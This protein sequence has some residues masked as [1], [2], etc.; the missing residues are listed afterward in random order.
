MHSPHCHI[1]A[2][3]AIASGFHPLFLIGNHSIHHATM[4][5]FSN[6]S[7]AFQQVTR[8]G[9]YSRD[10]EGPCH[11]TCEVRKAPEPAYCILYPDGWVCR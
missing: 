2:A 10:T 8:G 7:V 6:P 1:P 5:S 11:I 3:A 9:T 4:P